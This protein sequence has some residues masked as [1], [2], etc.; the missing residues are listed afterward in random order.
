MLPTGTVRTLQTTL[1]GKTHEQVEASLPPFIQ[2]EKDIS[3][4]HS[5]DLAEYAKAKKA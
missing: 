5:Y 2:I 1:L 3:K 4:D